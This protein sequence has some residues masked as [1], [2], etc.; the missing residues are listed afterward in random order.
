MVNYAS[1]KLRKHIRQF[2]VFKV[3]NVPLL[4]MF[5]NMKRQDQ[6]PE[7]CRRDSSSAM[8]ITELET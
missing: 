3:I 2:M 7:W 4:L 5:K 6:V 1:I 8:V